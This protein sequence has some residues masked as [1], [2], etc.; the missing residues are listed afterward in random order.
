MRGSFDLW[1]RRDVTS[2]LVGMMKAERHQA[3]NP[4]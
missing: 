2:V 4:P 3:V 1:P